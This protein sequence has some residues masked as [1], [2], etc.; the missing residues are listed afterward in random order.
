[1]VWKDQV[2]LVIQGPVGLNWSLQVTA[3]GK[4]HDVV[5]DMSRSFKD[6]AVTAVEFEG[7]F[8]MAWRGPPRARSCAPSPAAA[9]THPI[10]SSRI[11]GARPRSRLIAHGRPI[12]DCDSRSG[13]GPQP[14]ISGVYF[15]IPIHTSTASSMCS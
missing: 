3:D 13:I 12:L 1:M 11:S 14:L 4:A 6:G 5:V 8:Y 7:Q 15:K 2:H 10:R 9:R